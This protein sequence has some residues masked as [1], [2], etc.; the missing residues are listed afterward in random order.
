MILVPS[1]T[2]VVTFS[3]TSTMECEYDPQDKIIEPFYNKHTTS[4]PYKYCIRR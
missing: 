2:L 1:S 4:L 3:S